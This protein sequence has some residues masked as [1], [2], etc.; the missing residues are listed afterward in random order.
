MKKAT[1]TIISIFL[2]VFFMVGCG[3]NT[4]EL[5]EGNEKLITEYAVGL[6]LKYDVNYHNRLVDTSIVPVVE[7]TPVAVETQK[8]AV[9]NE[10]TEDASVTVPINEK[11]YIDIAQAIGLDGIAIQ[12]KNCDFYQAYPME[13]DDST[14]FSVIATENNKLLVVFFELTNTTQETKS[15]DLMTKAIRYK[16]KLNNNKNR[17][18]LSTMLIDDMGS[19][20]TTIEPGD[21][22]QAVLVIQVPTEEAVTIDEM[23]LT[24]ING[25]NTSTTWLF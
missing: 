6:L 12:Y 1:M 20:T 14:A 22:T 8:P 2:C 21:T 18:A 25:D 19:L 16:I 9:S 23:Q 5:S 17:T 10:S 3:V 11:V 13:D 7:S 15:V 24:I 4:V